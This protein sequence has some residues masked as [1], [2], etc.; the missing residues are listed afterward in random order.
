MADIEDE[1]GIGIEDEAGVQIGDEAPT[2]YTSTKSGT[3]APIGIPTR[4]SELKRTQTG[5]F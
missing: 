2:G 4:R 5:A 3:V 1:G